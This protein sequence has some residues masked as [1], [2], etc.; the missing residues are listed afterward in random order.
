MASHWSLSLDWL[1]SFFG[2]G[3]WVY[4]DH[5]YGNLGEF[6][7][8]VKVVDRHQQAQGLGVQ[9]LMVTLWHHSLLMYKQTWDFL[10][11]SLSLSSCTGPPNLSINKSII[12]SVLE[13]QD[14]M[15][16]STKAFLYSRRWSTLAWSS[17]VLLQRNW[18]FAKMIEGRGRWLIFCHCNLRWALHLLPHFCVPMCLKFPSGW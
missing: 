16:A 18:T 5:S 2:V 14:S 4:L 8:K 7:N 17:S 6:P 12:S 10:V 15:R 3:F 13:S 9:S 1:G 11:L